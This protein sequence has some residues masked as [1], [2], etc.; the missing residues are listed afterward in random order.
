PFSAAI[1]ENVSWRVLFWV[2]AALALAVA[3]L[4]RL[5]PASLRVLRDELRGDSPVLRHAFRVS[6][7]T[8]AG[9]I[10]GT[11]LPLG[12]GYW[13]PMTCVMVM[14]PDFSQTYARSVAR[15]GGSLIGV[16][17]ATA[18]VQG[19]G[20]GVYVS[21]GLAVLCAFCVFLVLST[22]YVVAS[23]FIS[24]YV[25]LLL[26]MGGEDWNQTV[27][28]RALL[29]LAG[30][31]LAMIA[32]AVYPA[33]ETPRLRHRLAD[34]LH[35]NGSYAAAVM[36]RYADPAG[37]ADED[38]RQALLDARDA[39]IAWRES[40]KRAQHE[41]VRHRGL[42]RDAADRAGKA[43][44]QLGRGAMLMEAHLP[45][46]GAAPVPAAADLAEALRRDTERAAAAVRERRTPHWDAVH[47]AIDHWDSESAPDT[48]LRTGAGLV[49]EA[50]DDLSEALEPEDEGVRERA[51]N[52]DP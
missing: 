22:G 48:L 39:R 12:H 24:A 50:L 4:I 23:V 2:V 21:G 8:A 25:V 34:W 17:A 51:A 45:D 16:G 27:P 42:S 28:E 43:L 44:S 32:Y 41:P 6:A 29:T 40:V 10:V 3:A 20:P 7:V 11:A 31:V 9:Y 26:G 35:A 5:V 13:A 49:A 18:V 52:P 1:A 33:W 38:I 14:R 19:A 46:R 36:D 30:G 47:E 15:F 37:R